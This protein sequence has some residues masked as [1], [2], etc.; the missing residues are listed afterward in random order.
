MNED[1]PVGYK[2]PPKASRFKP[3]VSG[4]TRGRPKKNKS[5]AAE[6]NDAL[7]ETVRVQIDGRQVEATK[8]S[9]IFQ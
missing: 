3:G 6:L 8:S 2:N 1:L 7:C 9:L 5:L 4:N